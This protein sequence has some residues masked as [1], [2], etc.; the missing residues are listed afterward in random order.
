MIH[1]LLFLLFH[2]PFFLPIEEYGFSD[3]E[4][5]DAIP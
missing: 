4:F 1:S 5:E 3:V 2:R